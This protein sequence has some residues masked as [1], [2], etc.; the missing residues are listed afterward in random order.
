MK[1]LREALKAILQAAEAL[2]RQ[3]HGEGWLL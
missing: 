1:K 3:L 2:G